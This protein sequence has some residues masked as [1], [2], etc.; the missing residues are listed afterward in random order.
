MISDSQYKQSALDLKCSEALIRGFAEVESGK[1]GGFSAPSK[2]VV[3]FEGHW[4]YRYTKGK[5]AASHPH[6]CYP[7]WTK[8]FYCKNQ[9]DEWARFQ[10]AVALDKTAALMSASYGKFQVMG[11]NFSICGYKDVESFFL[12]MCKS[13]DFHLEAF[14]QYVK[15][16]GLQDEMQR[17]DFAGLARGYNGS[18]YSKNK[19]DEKIKKAYEKY[20]AQGFS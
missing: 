9:A 15:N 16:T 20:K 2:P 10:E 12:D 17:L 8:Q 6:L 13:E 11:F 7:K 19:Y 3:L 5:Y 14:E 18:E 1:L 4:F